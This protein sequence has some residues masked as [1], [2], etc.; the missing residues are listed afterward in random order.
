MPIIR[1]DYRWLVLEDFELTLY[2]R[3]EIIRSVLQNASP[4]EAY[5]SFSGGK[6]STV[7]SHLIDEAMPHNEYERVFIDT[8]IE[9]RAVVNFVKEEQKRDPRIKIIKPEKNVREALREDGYPFKSKLHSEYVERYQ[10]SGFRGVSCRKYVENGQAG[11]TGRFSCPKSLLYQFS[12]DFNLKISQK[13]CLN[14]KKKPVR[15]YEKETGKTLCITGVRASEG[16]IRQH[17]AE[18]QGCVFRDKKGNVYRFNPISP[19]SDDFMDW[20]IQTRNIRLCELYYPPFSFTRTGC[21]GCPYNPKIAEE[22]EALEQNLPEERKQCELIFGPV[23]EEYRRI[24][25]RKMK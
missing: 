21:K 1:R 20:Y 5:V 2:D 10:R 22:L 16:G 12:P 6:D 13:C 4:E 9:F 24:G 8:G 7:L 17:H 25:Y 3:L 14:F 23:Y 11:K 15:R 19:V 18:T